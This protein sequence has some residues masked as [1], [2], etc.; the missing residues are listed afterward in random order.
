MLL[1]GGLSAQARARKRNVLPQ[2]NTSHVCQKKVASRIKVEK[3]EEETW[4]NLESKSISRAQAA[5]CEL[6]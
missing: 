5:P 4:G 2:A 6:S 1:E 3:I